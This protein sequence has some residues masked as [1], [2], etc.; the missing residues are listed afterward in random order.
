MISDQRENFSGPLTS[1]AF[2]V[3]VIDLAGKIGL[4][5][6]DFSLKKIT[7]NR[8]L[9]SSHL[10]EVLELLLLRLMELTSL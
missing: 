3:G 9:L 5:L 7:N 1:K 2:E 4:L 8:D 6:N 10:V